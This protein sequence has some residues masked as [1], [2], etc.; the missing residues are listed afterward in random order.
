MRVE[1]IAAATLHA[2]AGWED[3]LE[4]EGDRATFQ[5]F[6]SAAWEK[7]PGLR[8]ILID[9]SGE[10]SPWIHV[11]LNDADLRGADLEKAEVKDG[12]QVFLLPVIAGGAGADHSVVPEER[13]KEAKLSEADI[14]R[15]EKHLLLKDI[16]VK[17][18][19]R[20]KA[21]RVLVVGAGALGSAAIAYLAAAGV[22]T[23]GI[24]DSD[25][26][27]LKNL[28]SQI[29]YAKKDVDRP[30][31]AAARDAIRKG[32]RDIEVR[33]QNIRVTEE[34]A[35]ELVADYD[36]VID[37][38]DNYPARY[39]LSDACVLEKKPLV[40]GA[41]YQ[42]EGVVTVYGM[43]GGPCLR[44]QYPSPPPEGLTP[45]CAEN[46]VFSPVPGVIGSMQAAE[47][48]KLLIG[49]GRVLSGEMAVYDA[50]HAR[51]F[52]VPVKKDERCP[53]CGRHPSIFAVEGIDYQEL[54]GIRR[55]EEEEEI[56]SIDPKELADRMERGDRMTLVDVR[57]PHERAITRFAGA[58][59][60]PIGQLERR[61][62]E[63]DPAIDTIF[64]CKE[65]KRS[66]LA[67]RTLREAGYEGP[68]YTLKGGLDASKNLVLAHDGAWL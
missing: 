29:L 36:V 41:F 61:K 17:G 68:M 51:S 56:A 35:Q 37:A 33:E 58:I 64:I 45:S 2:F 3:V 7:N 11:F 42:F 39:I 66:I 32:N 9:E 47:A 5:E 65:G 54:C 20:I 19:K 31:A 18:Q 1:L 12:D 27:A 28:Q 48:L 55:E 34:N 21:G 4:L 44:C 40:Y 49:K 63:L 62:G 24:V 43:E 26:V 60:I 53:I 14:E 23:I 16:G 67:I 38:T 15:Y 59:V 6:L 50:W 52:R 22:G 8:E 13:R 30:K 46:G 25:L 57:E 10:V